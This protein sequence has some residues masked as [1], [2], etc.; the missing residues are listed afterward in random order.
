ML[1]EYFFSIKIPIFVLSFVFCISIILK[2]DDIE[3]EV[4]PQDIDNYAKQ[5]DIVIAKPANITCKITVR[6]GLSRSLEDASKNGPS[7]NVRTSKARWI[8]R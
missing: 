5:L 1:F 6:Y 4:S 8:V 2:A 3:L 7:I